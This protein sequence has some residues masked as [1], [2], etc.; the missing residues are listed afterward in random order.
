MELSTE[1]GCRQ[2]WENGLPVSD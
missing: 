1:G 2:E